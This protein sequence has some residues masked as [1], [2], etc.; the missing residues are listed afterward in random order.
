MKFIEFGKELINL[1][2]VQCFFTNDYN[3]ADD[4]EKHFYRLAAS[5][6]GEDQTTEDYK[7]K[8]E[9]DLRFKEITK[10]VFY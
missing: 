8:E 9:R 5:F 7:T 3:R 4:T 10:I 6:G 2:N 1:D